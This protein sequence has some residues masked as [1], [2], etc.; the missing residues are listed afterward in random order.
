M[1]LAALYEKCGMLGVKGWVLPSALILQE[2]GKGIGT[3]NGQQDCQ[4]LQETLTQCAQSWE[5]SDVHLD[6]DPDDV[7]FML[8]KDATSAGLEV[9]FTSLSAHM[10]T[11]TQIGV[12][13]PL[14]QWG[15]IGLFLLSYPL[16]SRCSLSILLD[17]DLLINCSLLS[18]CCACFLRPLR[19]LHYSLCFA[20][21][22]IAIALNR[23]GYGHFFLDLRKS[24]V[25]RGWR[26]ALGGGG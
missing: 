20:L 2:K 12:Y 1:I 10:R 24:G 13:C 22:A 6:I 3:E 14:L 17:L 15:E 26:E 9:Y 11:N 19:G 18:V 21:L 16:H 4:K 7:S 5:R 25:V 8:N 23:G